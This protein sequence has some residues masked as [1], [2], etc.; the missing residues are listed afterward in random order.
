MDYIDILG[1]R[2]ECH[3]DDGECEAR[4][5]EEPEFTETEE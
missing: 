5:F 1:D 3:T 4:Y 2:I